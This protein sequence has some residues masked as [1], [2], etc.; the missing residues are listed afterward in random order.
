PGQQQATLLQGLTDETE[1]EHLQVPQPA[2]HELAR[3][4]RRTAGEVTLLEQ[5]D[6]EPAGDGVER[7]PR[8]DDASTDDEDVQG[9]VRGRRSQVRQRAC[10]RVGTEGTSLGRHGPILS[11]R[12]KAW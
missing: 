3:P 5:A 6:A 2:V 1:V 11:T 10:S 9:L 4:G 12:R 7:R 8:P